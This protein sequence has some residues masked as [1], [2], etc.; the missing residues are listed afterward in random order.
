MA[1]NLGKREKFGQSKCDRASR[2]LY[3][4]RETLLSSMKDAIAPLDSAPVNTLS[5]ISCKR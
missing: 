2:M 3:I 1:I 4:A 5:L